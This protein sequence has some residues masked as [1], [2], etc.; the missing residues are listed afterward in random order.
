ML[1]RLPN[2]AQ[3]LSGHPTQTKTVPELPDSAG[4]TAGDWGRTVCL[5]CADITSILIF[6]DIFFPQ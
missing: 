5:Q 2:Y 1:C 4:W 6:P 3:L